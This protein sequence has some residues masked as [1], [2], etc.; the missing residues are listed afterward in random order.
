MEQKSTA[1][2]N[3]M[4]RRANNTPNQTDTSNYSPP[5]KRAKQQP[6]RDLT[7]VATTSNTTT[8]SDAHSDDHSSRA[9]QS[10]DVN[11]KQPLKD[12][13]FNPYLP[14]EEEVNSD[15]VENLEPN[16]A[17]LKSSWTGRVWHKSLEESHS[18]QIKERTLLGHLLC[19]E[20]T[21]KK[22]LESDI[23]RILG[24]QGVTGIGSLYKVSP[25]KFVLVSLDQK[26]R[27]RNFKI[28]W[29]NAVLAKQTLLWISTNGVDLSKMGRNLSS[30]LSTFLST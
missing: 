7:Q 12:G 28:Q 8:N 20:E 19:P 11:P 1:S 24:S 22:I 29:S 21:Q 16:S 30:L 5:T 2:T 6:E 3:P 13:I 25:S 10:E 15:P 14:S 4:E 9:E 27:R 23:F 18:A 26:Q 17:G